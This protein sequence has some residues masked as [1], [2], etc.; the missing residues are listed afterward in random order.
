MTKL[1][2]R[3]FSRVKQDD[4]KRLALPSRYRASYLKAFGEGWSRE[5]I[6][7]LHFNLNCLE[8]WLPE[9]HDEFAD[10]LESRGRFDQHLGFTQFRAVNHADVVTFDKQW[11]VLI[12]LDLRERVGLAD[13]IVMLGAGNK[14]QIW[15]AE[16]YEA[17]YARVEDLSQQ[18]AAT[19]SDV[20]RD[21]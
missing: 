13:D 7:A 9:E 16:A 19:P 14:V 10:D 6:C 5:L 8:L 4:K 18:M 12:P 2:Q 11:R 15:N 20:M 1:R 21:M 17:H 3:G